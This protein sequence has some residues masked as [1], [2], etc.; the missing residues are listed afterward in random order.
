M[1]I[2]SVIS[3]KELSLEGF[4]QGALVLLEHLAG[5]KRYEI[6]MGAVLTVAPYCKVW[7][8]A[9]FP[10]LAA[11]KIPE[12]DVDWEKWVDETCKRQDLQP[13]IRDVRVMEGHFPRT[14]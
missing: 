5:V 8:K 9:Q 3:G 2:L 6:G 14:P 7:L 12:G 4:N 13:L 10:D 1:S 11:V